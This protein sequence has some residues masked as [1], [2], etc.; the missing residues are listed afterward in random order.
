MLPWVLISIALSVLPWVPRNATFGV[1]GGGYPRGVQLPGSGAM[2]VCA[3]MRVY[4]A[5]VESARLGPFAP[6]GTVAVDG[7]PGADLSNCQLLALNASRVLASYRHH[8]GCAPARGGGT[9]CASYSLQLAASDDAGRTW[10]A[11]YSTIVNGSVGMWEP[12]LFRQQQQHG[13]ELRVAYSQEVTNHGNQSIVWQ[14][15]PDLGKSWLPLEARGG[16]EG[17]VISDGSEEGTRDGMPGLAVLA[18]GSVL[19]VFERGQ[20]LGGRFLFRV[21]ARRSFDGGITW[22]GARGV[23]NASRAGYNAGA[24]QVVVHRKSSEGG[25]ASEAVVTVSFMTDEDATGP[26][27]WV[28]DASVKVITARNGGVGGAP[29]DFVAADRELV[30]AGPGALWPGL[31]A[32]ENDGWV[33]FGVGGKTFV[34]GPL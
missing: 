5:A 19:A 28:G 26:A 6:V 12:F 32:T 30:R 11:Q 33:T 25:G 31:V 7:R 16:G 21:M 22:G 2:L 14:R 8:L 29:L 9:L 24:P 34:L 10:Q 27:S 1:G 13:G 3:G 17:G 15:S 18:D 20:R 4:E 23:Y